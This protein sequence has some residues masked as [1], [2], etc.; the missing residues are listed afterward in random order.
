MAVIPETR[1]LVKR[2][3]KTIAPDSVTLSEEWRPLFS[4]PTCIASASGHLKF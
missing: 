3:E 1:N 2:F 4:V